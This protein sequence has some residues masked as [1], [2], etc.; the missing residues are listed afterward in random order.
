MGALVR[1]VEQCYVRVRRLYETDKDCSMLALGTLDLCSDC[2]DALVW[3][4]WVGDVVSS[5]HHQEKF[6]GWNMVNAYIQ[7]S[8][9]TLIDILCLGLIFG[10]CGAQLCDELIWLPAQAAGII[11]QYVYAHATAYM[12]QNGPYGNILL[13]LVFALA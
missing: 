1:F 13:D 5:I 10:G 4:V 2:L 9:H 3:W 12:Y 7:R 6:S 8:I 11:S